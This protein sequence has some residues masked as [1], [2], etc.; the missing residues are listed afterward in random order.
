[1]EALK[2]HMDSG[3]YD[4][5]G[6]LLFIHPF[7]KFCFRHFYN[8]DEFTSHLNKEHFKCHVCLDK[9]KHYYYKNYDSLKNH[10]N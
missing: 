6:N 7:C 10:F 8:E 3:E 1:M 5:V 2:D 9:Y 4:D